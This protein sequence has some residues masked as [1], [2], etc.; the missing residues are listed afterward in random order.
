MTELIDLLRS[1]E[2][3]LAPWKSS[4][5]NPRIATAQ[6]AGHYET[7][8]AIGRIYIRQ[9][10]EILQAAASNEEERKET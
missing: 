8:A 4:H 10:I 5:P 1:A 6:Q 9:A 2:R 3:V 7:A